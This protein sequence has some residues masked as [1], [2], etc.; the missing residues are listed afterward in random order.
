MPENSLIR[1]YAKGRNG[2]FD[3]KK[4]FADT[5]QRNSGNLE[6]TVWVHFMSR[7]S[8]WP[9]PCYAVLNVEDARVLQEQLTVALQ[10][11][12]EVKV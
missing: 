10:K 6:H 11:A 5:F 4:I 12:S 3:V 7:R 1:S 2:Y 8:V 9:G